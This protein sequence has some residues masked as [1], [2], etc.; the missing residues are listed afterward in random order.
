MPAQDQHAEPTA[1]TPQVPRP[2]RSSVRVTSL[3]ALLVLIP[4]VALSAVTAAIVVDRWR[5]ASAAEEVRLE[6]D[7]M[8]QAMSSWF[9]LRAERLPTETLV[10]ADAMGVPLE[11]AEQVA[12]FDVRAAL[13]EA[14]R[15]VD[16]AGTLTGTPALAALV[17]EVEAFR[18]QVDRGTAGIDEARA[19]L[20]RLDDTARDAWLAEVRQVVASSTGLAEAS[21]VLDDAQTVEHS[22][23]ALNAAAYQT[24]LGSDLLLPIGRQSEATARDL[25]ANTA[26]YADAR[27]Q[28]GDDLGPA[29]SVAW[30]S[31]DDEPRVASFEAAL[32]ELLAADELAAPTT[33]FDDIAPVIQD[34][35]YRL[36]LVNRATLATA[37][38]LRKASG[39][40]EASAMADLRAFLALA[41]AAIALA[42]VLTWLVARSIV[43]PL[44]RLEEQAHRVSDGV[45]EVPD[46]TPAGPREVRVAETAFNQLVA[47]LRALEEQARVLA[48]GDLDDPVL[49]SPLPGRL[50]ESLHQSVDRL[51]Q[52]LREG[53]DLRERLAHQAM[54]DG[55]TGLLN[56]SAAIEVLEAA[57]S[58]ERPGHRTAVLFVDLDAFKSTNDVHGHA[59]GDEVLR[60]SAER[61]V[62]LVRQGDVVARLGG[63]E[64]VAVLHGVAG[65]AEA[66]TIAERIVEGLAEP[67][68]VD[69]HQVAAE[70]SVGVALS[71][72]RTDALDLLRQ[73]DLAMYRAKAFGKR[74]AELYDEVLQQQLRRR[75]EVE[76]ELEHGLEDDRFELH[77]QPVVDLE[78]GHVRAVEA[79]VRWRRANGSLSLPGEFLPVAELS[80]LVLDLDRRVLER[81]AR[82]HVEWRSRGLMAST[83][84]A[85]NVSGR[86]LVHRDF[87]RDILTV[88]DATGLDPT[89]LTVE[90]AETVLLR[91]LPA[92]AS[93]LE[94]LRNVGI[95]VAIDDFGTGYTSVGELRDLPADTLKIDRSFVNHLHDPMSG[96]ILQ[97]LI[98]LASMMGIEIV[99]EGVETTEQLD[100]LRRRRCEAAQGYLLARPMPAPLLE[101]WLATSP[102]GQISA[103]S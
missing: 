20:Q 91:D 42:G 45:L 9:R 34:G 60:R 51:S 92:V 35:L 52:S 44:R 87:V 4:V 78:T 97:L 15:D 86:H 5:T 62:R 74:R 33:D 85:V 10:A 30:Q 56:R 93:K 26:R 1:A 19:F 81:A 50:G 41:A 71:T 12:G 63:D 24:G 96:A 28:M 68:R 22:A 55:L 8:N 72:G 98:D 66:M 57:L 16:A 23:E 6:V 39:D 67:C 65:S 3:L 49:T 94:D 14:R 32:D 90:V 13:D 70:A 40:L 80:D 79:L 46:L 83:G 84:L 17:P 43:R 36:E 53:E 73:A 64:F 54:H 88:V 75:S 61:L 103:A 38:D 11:V 99:A 102:K 7:R 95:R 82:Q 48:S 18:R 2:P 77:Y 69:D 59:V 21:D 76:D 27:R 101:A 89:A 31:V 37:S 58:S 47:N 29:A 100:E 25:A